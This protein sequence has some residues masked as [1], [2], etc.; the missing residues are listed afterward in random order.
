MVPGKRYTAETVFESAKRRRWIIVVP[1]VVIATAT[2]IFARLT[3]NEYRSETMILV[4]PQRIPESYVRSTVT[5]RIEDRLQSISQQILSRTRL[6][7][8]ILDFDLYRQQRQTTVMESAM[9]RSSRNAVTRPMPKRRKTPATMAMTMGMGTAS[10]ARR[11]HPE[12][13]RRTITSPAA[14]KAPITSA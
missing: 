11:T 12:R 5:N 6:E 7:R 8:I 1:F 14:R 3:P 10:I 13:P 4:V 9:V 2:A